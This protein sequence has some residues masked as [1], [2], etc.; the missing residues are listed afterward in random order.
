LSVLRP[1][2]SALI[3]ALDGGVRLWRADLFQFTLQDGTNFYWTSF[4]ND[5][6]I[7]GQ[8]YSS[9]APWLSR[10]K[11][12]VVNT[13][14]VP[15]MTVNL[16]ALN[17]SFNG[18][19]NIKLQI[20]NGVFDG[21]SFLY[22]V[23][24]LI[25]NSTSFLPAVDT[26]G[27]DA[28]DTTGNTVYSV[29]VTSLQEIIGTIDVFGGMVGSVDITGNSA[30]ITCKGKNNLLAQYTPRNVYQT[31][32]VHGFCDAGCTLSAASFTSSFTV[33]ASPQANFIPWSGT[34]PSN[35]AAYTNGTVT[36]TSGAA[37]GQQRTVGSA[38]SSGLTLVYPLYE[39]PS[40]GDTFTAFQGCDKTLDSGSNQS[41][42]SRSNT[43]NFRGFPFT[44][45][46]D[47]AY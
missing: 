19:G 2:S 45:P 3:A 25:I 35:Y 15:T 23:A 8:V 9:K 12:E 47:A 28:V 5:V 38:T 44:P 17:T 41:C 10:S 16:D 29:I 27:Q 36:M 4:D 13:M 32:C 43:Q 21:A 26:T 39:T 37:S 34:A 14:Q 22:S 18:G 33:G 31:G 1:A 20:V 46:P 42:T 30:Q 11:W 24:F 7:G 40:S 6:T